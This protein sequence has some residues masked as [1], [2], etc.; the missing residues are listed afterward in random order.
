MAVE[1]SVRQMAEEDVTKPCCG[2]SFLMLLL[3]DIKNA[4]DLYIIFQN[5]KS[6]FL[7]TLIKICI[8]IKS[9]RC[10]AIKFYLIKHSM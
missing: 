10:L 4:G 9:Y 2:L 3:E 8:L 6:R 5:L 1:A 7:L